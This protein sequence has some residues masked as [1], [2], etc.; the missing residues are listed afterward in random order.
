[1]NKLDHNFT[2]RP[3]LWSSIFS[4]QMKC[5]RC[6]RTFWGTSPSGSAAPLSA[7][8]RPCSR[9]TVCT[10][11]L[12]STS[13][14]LHRTPPCPNDSVRLSISPVCWIHRI[15]C[16]MWKKVFVN[17][18]R[19]LW[20]MFGRLGLHWRWDPMNCEVMIK[21]VHLSISCFIYV[22]ACSSLLVDALAK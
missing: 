14:R 3:R 1:M 11:G 2:R 6:S 7:M 4:M 22:P 17:V 8:I 13:K 18:S 10:L 5:R 16:I 12:R 9:R 20:S 15:N 21:F 19:P